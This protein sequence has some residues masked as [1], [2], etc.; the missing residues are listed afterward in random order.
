M[1]T[2]INTVADQ[3]KKN[4]AI[5]NG[6]LIFVFT[7]ILPCIIGVAISLVSGGSNML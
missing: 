3:I 5:T 4:D 2:A 1:K 7:F 6:G